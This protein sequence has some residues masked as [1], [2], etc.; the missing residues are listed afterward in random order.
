[1][2]YFTLTLQQEKQKQAVNTLI[3]SFSAIQQRSF[4]ALSL[5]MSEQLL[6]RRISEADVRKIMTDSIKKVAEI[7]YPKTAET[8][9]EHTNSSLFY[10]MLTEVEQKTTEA[11][12]SEI[13]DI[14]AALR[15]ELVML[16]DILMSWPDDILRQTITYTSAV[17]QSDGSWK[18]T[19]QTVSMYK[20]ELANLI[21]VL[22]QQINEMQLM[23]ETIM[24][25]IQDAMNKQTQS[26]QVVSNILLMMH[27]VAEAAIRNLKP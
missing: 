11:K 7:T 17:Q 20:E 26:F 8:L 18:L 13:Q 14:I 25:E 3:S 10:G 27:S 6:S 23:L 22:E 9:L 12:I 4:R 16:K 19:E 15:E 1:M 5:H 24:L 21:R 2:S